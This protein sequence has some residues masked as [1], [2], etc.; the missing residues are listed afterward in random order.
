VGP[1]FFFERMSVMPSIKPFLNYSDQMNNLI[2][3]RRLVMT[4][5]QFGKG[6]L[7]GAL[8]HEL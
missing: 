7:V 1:L 2:Q 5:F 3:N 8:Q 6:C 4:F